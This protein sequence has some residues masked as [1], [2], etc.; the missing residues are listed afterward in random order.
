MILGTWDGLY[1]KGKMGSNNYCPFFKCYQSAPK[2][3]NQRTNL[4]KTAEQFKYHSETHLL[5]S[6]FHSG[7]Q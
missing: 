5:Y 6:N 1:K 2:K 4:G 7:A 3:K